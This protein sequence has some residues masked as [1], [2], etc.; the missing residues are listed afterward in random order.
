MPPYKSVARV[1]DNI[2]GI[3]NYFRGLADGSIPAG[4]L[5]APE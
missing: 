1:V 3:Y 2:D 5:P 4:P